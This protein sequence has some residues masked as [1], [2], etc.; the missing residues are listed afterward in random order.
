LAFDL[1]RVGIVFLNT[2]GRI[3][4]AN[5]ELADF[6][7]YTTEELRGH[8]IIE[9]THP[10]DRAESRAF[11]ERAARGSERSLQIEKR[12]V[13]K[14][15]ETRWGL[16]TCTPIF[17]T[18][19]H[20]LYLI[21][22]VQNIT[23]SKRI[24]TEQRYLVELLELLN[25]DEPVRELIRRALI[26]LQTVSGCEAVGIRLREGEDFPYYETRGFSEEFVQM[27]NSLCAT[28]LDGQ[29]LRDTAGSPVLDCMCGN[30][31][32]GRFDPT[33]PFFSRHGSFYSSCTSELLATTSEADRQARTR[34]RC[35]GEGYESVA[36]IPLRSGGNTFGL[37]QFNDRERGRFSPEKMV[38]LERL[39]DNLSVALA[40]RRIR[41]QLQTSEARY[42]L[43]SEA[44]TD[45][46]YRVRIEGGRVVE[47]CH[48]EGCVAVTGYSAEEFARDPYLW[49]NMVPES[50]RAA[51]LDLSQR[52][53][54]GE[55]DLRLEHRILRKDGSL[56]WVLNTLV[57]R[58]KLSGEVYAYEGLIQDITDRKQ[59]E[60]KL[61]EGEL[62]YRSIVEGQTAVIFRLKPSG[63][64][65]FANERFC[66]VFGKD[67][68]DLV[69][70]AW[71][72]QTDPPG[73]NIVSALISEPTIAKPV[74]EVECRVLD[75]RSQWRWYEFVSRGLFDENGW[76]TET[77]W[78]GVTSRK[79][80]YEEAL[81]KNQELTQRI[82]QT[83]PNLVYIYD[84]VEKRN[85][86]TNQEAERF[87]GYSP[88]QVRNMGSLF[89]D[90]LLHPRTK[91][92]SFD[93]IRR[94]KKQPTETCSMWITASGTSMA[95][96]VIF[97]VATRF[98]CATA[99][100]ACAR[101]W[102]PRRM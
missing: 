1:S 62:R 73:A 93:N 43:I 84:L 3:L 20:I 35:N 54:A 36:L 101:F 99:R 15:G 44:V 42:R 77:Q 11:L 81:H 12:Y 30:V 21:S 82:L 45:Y 91:N 75:G 97:T 38:L 90:R 13:H 7:G 46:L 48:G 52:A 94:L 25:T 22:H 23:E 92:G 70:T 72:P 29:L 83:V 17:D 47:T 76:M 66:E 100:D 58:Q 28:D 65:S 41:E 8:S 86:F 102:D 63:I 5:P 32:C 37:L 31:L 24:Q 56:R 85:I 61:R 40:E 19:G 34:N 68:A 53:Q 67:R 14:H 96:G 39:T 10:D 6:L 57:P 74:Y 71:F 60:S 69:G 78:S 33:Q 59:L 98:S 95:N 27:E 87:L 80:L 88:E 4:R 9:V 51:V 26:F 49:L 50:D 89:L 64:C 18:H 16:V 79:K 55:C 2:H